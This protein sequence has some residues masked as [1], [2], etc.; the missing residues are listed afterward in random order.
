MLSMHCR[1]HAH[2]GVPWLSRRRV[3][4]C[5][6][7]Q[8]ELCLATASRTL[9]CRR[10][11]SRVAAMH[12]RSL[13]LQRSAL[14][15]CRAADRASHRIALPCTRAV[16][17]VRGVPRRAVLAAAMPCGASLALPRLRVSEPSGPCLRRSLRG[18]S[19]PCLAAARPAAVLGCSVAVHRESMRRLAGAPSSQDRFL[20]IGCFV[21]LLLR[22]V[23]QHRATT[24]F[25]R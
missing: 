1:R 8:S 5:V 21:A 12:P 6:A 10:V 23:Q 20:C 9:P 3:H 24:R 15:S 19:L 16:H 17:A 11:A 13:S 2:R 22:Y 14:P 4:Q 25:R 7:K 18:Q